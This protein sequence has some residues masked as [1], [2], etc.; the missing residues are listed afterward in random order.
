LAASKRHMN[1]VPFRLTVRRK[2][3]LGF[4]ALVALMVVSAGFAYMKL[5]SVVELE[6]GIR[7]VR[8][9]AAADAAAIQASIGAAAAALQGYVLFG[10]DPSDAS[11]FRAARAEAW[12]GCDAALA[13]LIQ[14][15]RASREEQDADQVSSIAALLG[16]YH[17]LQNQ[18]EHLAIGQG[19]D[20]MGRAY[21]LLKTDA[22]GQQTQLMSMLKKLADEQHER[23]NREIAALSEASHAAT[24][25]LWASTLLGALLGCGVASLLTKRMAVA[26]Q[27]LLMRAQAISTGD[28]CGEELRHTSADEIGDLMLAMNVMQS[29]LREMIV[30]VAQ[31]CESVANSSENLGG[32]S[33]QMSSNAEETATQSSV[34]SASAEQVTRNLQTVATATEEMTSSI[35][36]IAA[37]AHE[38]ARVAT[39]AVKTAEATNA[40]VAKLGES[41]AEIG[42][43]IKVIT[44]IAQQTNLL[45][46]NA[47]IEAARAGE[48]GKGFA[49]VANEVKELAKETAKATE[50][51]SRKIEAIQGDTKGAVEAIAQISGII[52]QINDISNTIASAVEEQTAT[53]NEIAR[54]VQEGAKGGSQVAENIVAVVTAA[55][56]TTQG[57]ADTQTAAGELARMAAELQ[58]VV[59]Q[60]KYDGIGGGA[61]ASE[62]PTTAK[63]ARDSYLAS[64]AKPQP[65]TTARQ[66]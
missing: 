48:A 6:E 12:R 17:E 61:G 54:N 5:A 31:T 27:Q 16:T 24:I 10:S 47:T 62:P 2:L 34:V 19:N 44:S 25:M 26:F 13:D 42:Q 3:A 15:S 57:A 4:G 55:K 8:Y 59:G 21:E 32:V 66:H 56:S 11:H 49:V 51:I 23:T 63:L 14:V 41:S 33:H 9:P 35:K 65:G 64:R 1:R 7:K 43:V 37:N 38:A 20:A 22:T 45:A 29:R 30:A 46:L 52:N 36:E 50:D 40:T 39:T 53:T 58:K 60:F 28:L 18:I